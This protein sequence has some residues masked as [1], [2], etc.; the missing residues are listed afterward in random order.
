MPR[1]RLDTRGAASFAMPSPFPAISSVSSAAL[2]S[3]RDWTPPVRRGNEWQRDAFSYNE[4]IG[5]VGYLHNLT[6]N[7]VAACDLRVV[8]EGWGPDGP[9][10]ENRQGRRRDSLKRRLQAS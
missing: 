3:V 7:L 6:A 1:A 5:E 9:T 10:Q 8:E 4:L 2:S